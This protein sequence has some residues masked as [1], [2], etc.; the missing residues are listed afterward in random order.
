MPKILKTSKKKERKYN[1]FTIY[2]IAA[3]KGF[4]V[5][6][7]GFAMLSLLVLKNSSESQ[8]LYYLSFFVMALGGFVSGFSA[9][10]KLQ[11]RGFLNGITG[12]AIYMVFLLITI[13]CLMR[14]NISANILLTVPLCLISGFLGGTVGANT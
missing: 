6:V 12:S 1:K 4:L 7:I 5:F 3:V 9:Y 11:D 14:F 13:I 2:C 8:V 10:R